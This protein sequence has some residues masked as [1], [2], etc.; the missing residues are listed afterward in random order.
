VRKKRFLPVIISVLVI[1]VAVG[2]FAYKN[3]NA[4]KGILL[5]PFLPP[6]PE[7]I[8]DWKTYNSEKFQFSFEYP[9][10]WTVICKEPQTDFWVMSSICDI[11]APN[12][13]LDNDGQLSSGAYVAIAVEKVD[14][15]YKSLEDK[16][17][18]DTK[19][20]GYKIEPYSLDNVS[21]YLYTLSK[22]NE[23]ISKNGFYF[24]HIS[25]TPLDDANQYKPTIDQVLST[26]K[27]TPLNISK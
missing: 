8:T 5:G 2:Y 22:N 4:P 12:T 9:S 23:F 1:L 3:F 27:L 24:I 7:T 10:N 11:R 14:S 19:K 17:A 13:T 25:W 15:K 20:Y 21:G 6:T 26:F 16:V 18:F